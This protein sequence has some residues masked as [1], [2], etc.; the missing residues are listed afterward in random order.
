MALA[1]VGTRFPEAQL[2]R[3]GCPLYTTVN[4]PGAV[5]AAVL[6]IVTYERIGRKHQ[7]RWLVGTA[8]TQMSDSDVAR[9]TAYLE[10]RA[11]SEPILSFA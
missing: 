11:K 2:T 3:P 9:L 4:L 7:T 5:I 1:F 10:K 6:S 8:I